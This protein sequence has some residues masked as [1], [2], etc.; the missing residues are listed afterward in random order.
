M[1][2]RMYACARARAKLARGAGYQGNLMITFITNAF[3]YER[4]SS[5]YRAW[6]STTP[7]ME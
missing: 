1:Y 3:Y 2:V 5:F 6:V 4:V 7:L